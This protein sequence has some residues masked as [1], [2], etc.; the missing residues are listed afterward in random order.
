MGSPEKPNKLEGPTTTYFYK[1]S[2]DWGQTPILDSRTRPD[3]R[4]GNEGS[5]SL[6]FQ[7]S[8]YQVRSSNQ[9]RRVY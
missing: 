4:E 7:N 8:S 5:Y 2:E 6:I 3:F 1:T 9:G